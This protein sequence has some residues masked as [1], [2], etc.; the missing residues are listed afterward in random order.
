MIRAI[1]FC[2]VNRENGKNS[3]NLS[4]I[5]NFGTMKYSYNMLQLSET[6]LSSN[7]TGTNFTLTLTIFNLFRS[8]FFSILRI[9][10]ILLYVY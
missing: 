4:E 10:L 8:D 9:K 7:Q 3:S 1:V 6:A 5:S 2:I